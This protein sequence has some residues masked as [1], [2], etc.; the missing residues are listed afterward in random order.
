MPSQ[1]GPQ[2]QSLVSILQNCAAAAAGSPAKAV[3]RVSKLQPACIGERGSAPL[4]LHLHSAMQRNAM[5]CALAHGIMQQSVFSA[6]CV[7]LRQW[8]E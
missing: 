5:Q 8:N 6:V 1:W 4:H 3:H 2:A 7:K